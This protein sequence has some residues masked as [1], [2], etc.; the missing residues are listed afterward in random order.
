MSQVAG[1]KIGKSGSLTRRP[2]VCGIPR[3]S[4]LGKMTHAERPCVAVE[5][6]MPANERTIPYLWHKRGNLSRD[7][8]L[9]GWSC[10]VTSGHKHR[11]GSA[12]RS[13][14]RQ[15]AVGGRQ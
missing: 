1:F 2:G 3:E 13:E 7:L 15:R 5:R 10:A 4:L 11:G 9:T 6:K 14:N 8:S 12:N